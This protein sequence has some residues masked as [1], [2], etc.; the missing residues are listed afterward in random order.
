MS[1][2]NAK[3]HGE[4]RK[5]INNIESNYLPK[6]GGT[7]TGAIVNT[8]KTG[9]SKPDATSRLDLLSSTTYFDGGW[10]SIFGKDMTDANNRQGGFELGVGNGA[11]V[12]RLR[13]KQD[14]T[15]TW[16]GSNVIVDGGILSKSLSSSSSV[17]AK[18]TSDDES[19]IFYTGTDASKGATFGGYGIN[20]ETYGGRFYAKATDG[21]NEYFF[22]CR[23]DGKMTWCGNEIR[24]VKSTYTSGTT[25]YRV[26]SDGWIEQG[27][28][29]TKTASSG[30]ITFPKAFKDT[31]YT[32][33]GQEGAGTNGE[34]T[35]TSTD[36]GGYG[37]NL[38]ITNF[39]TTTVRY[40]CT[41]TRH[42][43]WYACGY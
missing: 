24:F 17:L 27:G 38:G 1:I 28:R 35:G 14:K 31:N 6:S 5:A 18:K 43:C 2:N 8:N 26:W 13:G 30:T 42:I 19:M 41:S 7:M 22:Y 15:L 20:Y 33:I 11:S 39:T 12:A 34:A 16:N 25:W 21:T 10:I 4:Y 9:I 37:D 3:N 32:F 29:I 36:T 23:P 40:S